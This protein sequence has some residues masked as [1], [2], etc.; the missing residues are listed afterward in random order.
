MDKLTE[1]CSVLVFDTDG[2]NL[3]EFLSVGVPLAYS[4]YG[5]QFSDCLDVG[6]FCDNDAS[7]VE[8]ILSR[9]LQKKKTEIDKTKAELLSDGYYEKTQDL[10]IRYQQYAKEYFEEKDRMA[11]HY[12]KF[13]KSEIAKNFDDFFKTY[14]ELQEGDK[15]HLDSRFRLASYDKKVLLNGK[16]TTIISVKENK[17]FSKQEFVKLVN[18]NAEELIKIHESNSKLFY[19]NALGDYDDLKMTVKR[20]LKEH[21]RVGLIGYHASGAVK[22][23]TDLSI[24]DFTLLDYLKVRPKCLYW[25]ER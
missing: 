7:S 13:K 1:P 11:G 18:E 6:C 25:F 4:G 12:R 5:L 2:D 23:I 16:E 17:V 19:E 10:A 14:P 15:F 8:E 3:V 24:D 20:L 9:H 22:E 21:H